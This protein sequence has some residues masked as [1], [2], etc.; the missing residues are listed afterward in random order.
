MGASGVPEGGRARHAARG[1]A[2]GLP[3]KG[4]A[5]TGKSGGGVTGGRKGGGG[6]V[7]QFLFWSGLRYVN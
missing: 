5:D 4:G 1:D 3:P 2:R 6:V 7:K